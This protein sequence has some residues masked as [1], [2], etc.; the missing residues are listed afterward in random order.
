M[1]VQKQTQFFARYLHLLPSAYASQDVN[2]VYLLFFTL[3]SLDVLGALAKAVSDPVKADIS[4]WLQRLICP[5]T[6]FVRGS[7]WALIKHAANAAVQVTFSGDFS[8]T[9]ERT[10]KAVSSRSRTGRRCRARTARYAS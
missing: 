5:S 8:L 6:G 2:R 1:D 3:A 10:H 9:V 4:A 7:T